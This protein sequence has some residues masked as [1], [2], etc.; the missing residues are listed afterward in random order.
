[1]ICLVCYFLLYVA[2][3]SHIWLALRVATNQN[4]WLGIVRSSEMFSCE[5]RL[6]I[7]GP[8]PEFIDPVFTKTSPKRSFSVIENERFGL[9]S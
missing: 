6:A 5:L 2:R 1:M 7:A 8:V 3:S 9:V 4:D